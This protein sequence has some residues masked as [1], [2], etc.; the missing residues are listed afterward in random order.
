MSVIKWL[1]SIL[2]NAIFTF[3]HASALFQAL[4]IIDGKITQQLN[5]RRKRRESIGFIDASIYAQGSMGFTPEALRSRPGHLSY[6]QQQV[7]N[8]SNFT[9]LYNIF[10]CRLFY[11]LPVPLF[12]FNF[13]HR[14]LFG[15]LG[16]IELTWAQK[17]Y[18]LVCIVLPVVLSLQDSLTLDFTQLGLEL[19]EVL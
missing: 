12:V 9:S 18:L 19:L 15:F 14:I 3:Y 8:V 13:C 17:L 4:E 6:S 10:R 1:V 11:K 5:L 7:Y 2:T 16:R